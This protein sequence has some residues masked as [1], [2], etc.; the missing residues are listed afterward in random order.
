MK[1]DYCRLGSFKECKN[2]TINYDSDIN[3]VLIFNDSPET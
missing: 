2:N 3:N 1:T